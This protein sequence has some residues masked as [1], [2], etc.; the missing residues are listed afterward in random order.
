MKEERGKES[1]IDLTMNES[2]NG[3]AFSAYEAAR[4]L[5]LQ[6]DGWLNAESDVLK[7]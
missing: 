5:D 3:S 6:G 2:H 4:S 1:I 7:V